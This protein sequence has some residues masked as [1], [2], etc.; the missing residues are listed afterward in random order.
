MIKTEPNY[1]KMPTAKIKGFKQISY[2]PTPK[3]SA[4][5]RSGFNDVVTG[6]NKWFPSAARVA[7]AREAVSRGLKKKK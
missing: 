2:T 4:D 6:G 1:S 5:Y 7:G 3:D